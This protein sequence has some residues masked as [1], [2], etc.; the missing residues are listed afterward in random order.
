MNRRLFINVAVLV[1]TGIAGCLGPDHEYTISDA[2]VDSDTAPFD[3]ELEVIDADATLEGPAQFELS[4]TNASNRPVE[5][6]NRGVW[7]FGVLRIAQDN[8]FETESTRM[9][10]LTSSAY[11]TS[12]HVTSEDNSITVDDTAL[13]D[14]VNSGE[15]VSEV[16]SLPGDRLSVTGEYSI[17]GVFDPWLFEFSRHDSDNWEQFL[18]N[19]SIVVESSGL[20]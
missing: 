11:G 5:V 2:T 16:Y 17:Y 7:P 10:D 8:P 14:R 15:T 3:M 20:F 9:A 6:R 18:P 4:V 1:T 13:R 19:T 12:E